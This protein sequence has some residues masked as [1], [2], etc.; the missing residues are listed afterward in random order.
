MDFMRFFCLALWLASPAA[1]QNLPEVTSPAPLADQIAATPKLVSTTPQAAEINETLAAFDAGSLEEL[2]ACDGASR[3]VQ[4]LLRSAKFYSMVVDE[5]GMCSGAAHPFFNHWL[6]TFDMTSGQPLFW[7]QFLPETL[8]QT[9]RPDYDKDYPLRRPALQALYLGHIAQN[10][11]CAEVYGDAMNFNFALDAKA[12]ALLMAPVGLPY[13]VT[14]CAE[15]AQIPLAE[16]RSLGLDAR[17]I[18]ALESGQ[19]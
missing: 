4:V 7:D 18:S 17:L 19:P 6:I 1:A 3:A 13:A 15:T 14:A 9:D 2:T 16:M 5:G 10:P 12:Q 8:L 11:D